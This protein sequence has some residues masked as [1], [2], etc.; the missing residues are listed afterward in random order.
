MT[1]YEAELTAAR[2]IMQENQVELTRI[3]AQN[4]MA[5]NKSSRLLREIEALKSSQGNSTLSA[6][7]AP[8]VAST[9]P[10]IRSNAP[11]PCISLP[12]V[13]TPTIAASAAPIPATAPAV[14]SPAG[15]APLQN[16]VA[17]AKPVVT[18]TPAEVATATPAEVATPA[19][20]QVTTPAPAE[21]SSPAG[22]NALIASPQPVK[23]VTDLLKSEKP[24]IN[25]AA[26]SINTPE[27]STTPAPG[28]VDTPVLTPVASSTP[29]PTTVVEAEEAV[30]EPVPE[31][32][33]DTDEINLPH[34]PISVSTPSAAAEVESR[35]IDGR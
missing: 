27:L 26:S 35:F 30:T 17:V 4:S 14:T 3:K 32:T 13:S 1:E 5:H 9:S 22:S 10:I 19:P 11:S 28:S 7:A 16:T 8:F 20:A 23:A 15:T 12:T 29:P 33:A 25:T 2:K 24:V 18:P 31:I 21:V 6:T 34:E